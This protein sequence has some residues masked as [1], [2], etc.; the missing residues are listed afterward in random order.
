MDDRD[1][2][3]RNHQQY[4]QADGGRYFANFV[5]P[6]TRRTVL[7]QYKA[8]PRL[9]GPKYLKADAHWIKMIPKLSI[10]IGRQSDKYYD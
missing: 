2:D 5:K 9:L 8:G 7:F 3:L 10:Y 4:L 6:V 1:Q